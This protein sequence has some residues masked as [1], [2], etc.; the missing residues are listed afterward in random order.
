MKRALLVLALAVSLSHAGL[1]V[2]AG[3]WK[4]APVN[5]DY[6]KA[7][8]RMDQGLPSS[9]N[10]PDGHALGYIP[11]PVQIKMIKPPV[12]KNEG[13]KYPASY[14]LRTA[15]RVT[16]VKDQGI[17]GTCWA[18]A[19]IASAESS[20]MPVDP[21]PD[22]SE[23]NMVNLDKFD[24]GFDDGGTAQMAI[25]YLARW[26]GPVNESDDPYPNPDESPT[27]LAPVKHLQSAEFLYRTAAD[28]DSVKAAVMD[29]GACYTAFCWDS[30]NYNSTT[31]AYYSNTQ[32]SANHAVAIVGWDDAFP[33]SSFTV[34]PPGDG[35]FLIKN[36]WGTEWGDKGYF[37]MSYHT[38]PI[39][40]TVCFH[41]MEASD[42]YQGSCEYDYFGWTG[43]L[44]KSADKVEFNW[45][46]NVFTPTGASDVK[47]V[48][49]YICSFGTDYEVSVYTDLQDATIP[50]SGT[51]AGTVSGTM[52]NVG[53]HTLKLPFAASVT[54][55][56]PFSVVVKYKINQ[57]FPYPIPLE[58]NEF[59][60]TSGAV[61]GTGQSF[62][63]SD[64]EKWTDSSTLAAGMAGNVCIKAFGPSCPPEKTIPVYHFSPG[65]EFNVAK[66]DGTQFA[67]K[68]DVVLTGGQLK[69]KQKKKAKILTKQYPAD[70][71]D[72]KWLAKLV[73]GYY[74]TLSIKEKK[75]DIAQLTPAV[76][77]YRPVISY[78]TT[79]VDQEG[80]RTVTCDG[81]YFGT[82]KTKM[83]F[84]YEIDGKE[85]FL[86]CKVT[87]SGNNVQ[88]N[89]E[90]KE[91][92]LETLR[93][94]G[95]D[96]FF[97][98]IRNDFGI[99]APIYYIQ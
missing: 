4:A 60:V 47:A 74:Y 22:Y 77:V 85:K 50:D 73:G 32:E 54:A 59:G 37:W 41:E 16:S 20:L 33:A 70:A 45:A 81:I 18:H 65:L 35:A 79:S 53:Y 72:C 95:V 48:G 84:S 58:Q 62:V 19:A 68:P 93:K 43:S 89:G 27:S 7:K 67:A 90:I 56:K 46:A 38:V 87:S 71:V 31:F 36:S 91:K 8:K 40:T 97:I 99:S 98:R 23:N 66:L 30:S 82:G 57:S 25:A 34:Q 11:E 49:F 64:G 21:N 14:D 78:P 52:E 76:R 2:I 88:V 83:L 24:Y 86:N 29:Y 1:N 6:V 39:T 28:N 75:K 69:E 13:R 9:F 5:P 42:N 94:K 15:D 63:S 55:G 44:G 61:T 17:Y 92:S 96:R 10:A 12:S 51:L 26:G 3:D 80:K